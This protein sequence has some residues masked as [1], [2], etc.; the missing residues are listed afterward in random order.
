MGSRLQ[1]VYNYYLAGREICYAI[2]DKRDVIELEIS[3]EN[4]KKR[5]ICGDVEHLKSQIREHKK[6]V[7]DTDNLL[8][9][10]QTE[11]EKAEAEAKT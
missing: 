2:T 9:R 1:P 5:D 3:D 10:V 11:K 8:R 7:L 4:K 6:Q